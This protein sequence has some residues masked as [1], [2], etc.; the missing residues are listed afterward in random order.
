MPPS[1]R[2]PWEGG[3]KPEEGGRERE[4]ERRDYHN[5]EHQLEITL[6]AASAES[7]VISDCWTEA[8]FCECR[9][10]PVDL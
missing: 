6:L 4:K 8:P 2:N 7:L 3:K 1:T 10:V 5:L 9:Y